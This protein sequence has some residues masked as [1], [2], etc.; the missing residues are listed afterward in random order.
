MHLNGQSVPAYACAWVQ[1]SLC[2][3]VCV[4]KESSQGRTDKQ[5]SS[6]SVCQRAA[7]VS[8]GLGAE[9]VAW[10]AGR[11]R[12]LQVGDASR[13]QVP[14]PRSQRETEATH[15]FRPSRTHLLL[16][17]EPLEYPSGFVPWE[18]LPLGLHPLSSCSTVIV[19]DAHRADCGHAGEEEEGGVS[20]P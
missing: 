19:Q 12:G 9:T 3:Y 5:L 13:D 7:E 16:E 20:L 1:S 18:A 4:N 6:R 17:S 15:R 11:G 14:S 8:A 10:G 2:V